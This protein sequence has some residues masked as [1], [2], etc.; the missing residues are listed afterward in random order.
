ML[1]IGAERLLKLALKQFTPETAARPR[2]RSRT[3]TRCG[4]ASA[5]T[6]RCSATGS[7]AP[8]SATFSL[9]VADCENTLEVV[10]RF[11]ALLELYREGLVDFEQPVSLDEL[12]VRWIG[13]DRRRRRPRH[14]RLRGHPRPSPTPP[15]STSDAAADLD[16]DADLDVDPDL[17]ADSGLGL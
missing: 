7:A 4:S 6:P 8:G 15:P 10:A 13:G 5:S 12:T 3:S 1:G 17:D 2:S 16:A 14:R 11:L 9:L